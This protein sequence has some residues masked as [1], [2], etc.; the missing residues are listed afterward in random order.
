MMIRNSDGIE[1]SEIE[2]LRKFQKENFPDVQEADAILARKMANLS[3]E[4]RSK[5]LEDLHGV[6]ENI[7][8]TPEL[9]SRSLFDLNVEVDKIEDKEAYLRLTIS[10]RWKTLSQETS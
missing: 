6:C 5:V 8:E 2:D 1:I 9:L 10:D 3:V 4:E 7:V